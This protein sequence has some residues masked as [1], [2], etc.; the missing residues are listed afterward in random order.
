VFQ[1][2]KDRFN[3]QLAVTVKHKFYAQCTF[4]SL[5]FFSVICTTYNVVCT[6]LNLDV[7]QSTVISTHTRHDCQNAFLYIIIIIYRPVSLCI[8]NC[9]IKI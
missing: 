1:A 6:V 4:V 5:T 7:P 9:R 8:Y 3:A 2:V